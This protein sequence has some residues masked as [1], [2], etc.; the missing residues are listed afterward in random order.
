MQ[1]ARLAKERDVRN[2]VTQAVQ[3]MLPSDFQVDITS[4]LNSVEA[5]PIARSDAG[6]AGHLH[7]PDTL[8]TII[9]TQADVGLYQMPDMQARLN[10]PVMD[11]HV[12]RQAAAPRT[13]TDTRWNN[14][15]QLRIQWRR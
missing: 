6:S 14:R 11:Q 9:D 7:V 5:S 8:P 2:P 1:Q 10:T 4:L 12:L 13:V 3:Q 15:V